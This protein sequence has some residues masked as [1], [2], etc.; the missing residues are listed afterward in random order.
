MRF[1]LKNMM[2]RGKFIA[3]I[4]ISTILT[5]LVGA[6]L[7]VQAV[8][9]TTQEQLELSRS[10]LKAEQQSAAVSE[11]SA[12]E[13][14]ADN[15]GLF[16]SKTA[17]DLILSYDFT[18]LKSYQEYAAKDRDV[19]YSA[20]LKPDGEA[21]TDYQ[22]PADMSQVI[23]KRYA[24]LSGDEVLGYVLLGMNKAGMFNNLNT[25]DTRIGDAVAAIEQHSSE[26]LGLFMLIM[27]ADVVG[28]LVL[29]SGV[30][31]ILFRK[32]VITP[33]LRT[34]DT[35]NGLAR[36]DGDL[37][38]R[39]PVPNRDEISGLCLAVNNFIENLQHMVRN[40]VTDVGRLSEEANSLRESGSR[41][42]NQSDE[43]SEGS[44]QVASAMNEMA[45]TVQ[46][47]A[48]NARAARDAAKE[49]DSRANEGRQVVDATT[50][51]INLLSEE[52]SKASA[53][54]NAVESD[55]DAIGGVLDVIRGVS[56]QTNLL[57]L[58]AAIEAARA[59]EQGRGFA[60][61]ADEVRTLASRTQASTEEIQNMIEKLQSGSR[62][63]VALMMHGNEK[64]KETVAQAAAA[65]SALEQIA[66]AVNT[67]NEMNAQIATAAG[68]QSAVA[69]EINKSVT[70]V[71]DTSGKTAESAHRTAASSDNLSN[72]ATS[73]ES[74]VGRFRI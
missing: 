20:Y 6:L 69:G 64:T 46:D 21:M 35:I 43:L 1:L 15:L 10:A 24:I 16:M 42:M 37:T 11:L 8:H 33:L 4:L 12:L 61:V 45:A 63:A 56:E 5:L 49:A 9:Q 32:L 38:R 55:S 14:K 60:V 26:S 22:K 28:V 59:G 74:M 62:N 53:V 67:I 51:A 71:N 65:A 47:V 17:L 73:L 2:L 52:I 34:T 57:A 30:A 48:S 58:N 41:L 31:Y 66:E 36:G 19:A 18:A 70:K 29:I 72:I 13:S 23:E 54:I 7:L 40:I 25:S 68:Q 27:A 39:L 3:P 44:T 50:D